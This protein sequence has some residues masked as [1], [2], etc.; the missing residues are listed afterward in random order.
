MRVQFL[1]F[2][3]VLHLVFGQAPK[4]GQNT[5]KPNPHA[6]NLTQPYTPNL[7]FLLQIFN[8]GNGLPLSYRDVLPNGQVYWGTKTYLDAGAFDPNGT[9]LP[10]DDIIAIQERTLSRFGLNLYD[11]AVWEIALALWNRWDVAEIYERNILYTSTT[12]P[13]GRENGNPGGIVNIRAD[14]T[15]FKYGDDKISG[16]ALKQITYPG[17]ATHFT[18][19]ADGKPSK[20]GVKKGPGALFYRMIGP[21][22]QM[23][24]PLDGNY[25]NSWK[26]PWPNN[27]H[28]TPWNSYGLIHFN[29]WKPI[30]GENVWGGILGPLQALEIK[31]G[32]NLTNTTCGDPSAEPQLPCDWTKYDSTP[33]P[34]Q[35]AITLLPG[36][37][38]LQS[39]MGSLYH[40]PWGAKI[41]P[42]DSDEG[43]NV[44]NENNSSAYVSLK[45]L[46]AVLKNYTKGGGDEMLT[47]G[48]QTAEKLAKGLED[49]FSKHLLSKDGELPNGVRLA[50]QGGHINST[51]Y[52]PVPLNDVGGIA[53]DCQ[54][55][56][57]TVIGAENMDKWYGPDMAYKI[58][59][60]AKKY[61][62]FYQNGVLAGVGYTSLRKNSSAAPD[63][64]IWSAEWT[65]GAIN[66]CQVIGQQYKALGKMDYYT[67]L[68]KDAQS[69]WNEVTKPWPD[70]LQFSDG[71]YVYANKR[72][73]IPWGWYANPMGATCSTGWAVIQQQN[74]NPFEWG[75]GDKP[76]LQTPPHLNAIQP[77]P[78]SIP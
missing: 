49:W 41:Y 46:A 69:M 74:Y 9:Q 13:A 75:G 44:S 1:L 12:G 58:W 56:G 50:Y 33:P 24:D 17:N 7:I 53:I 29:D 60:G 3:L 4:S 2:V 65:F 26:Y 52:H 15:D 6:A 16:N 61:A 48:Q 66:M 38:A 14:S 37:E 77:I 42:Y 55:W 57:T 10:L 63:N 73:F 18:Q 35:L 54:T 30:I 11:G 72:F 34:V 43:F 64:H 23:I 22:Y 19:D 45:I 71:S 78:S 28:K 25:A 68:M 36:L 8:T 59:V 21:K 70:G 27:D 40:C 5:W 67:E 31:S 62:G 47:Y 32:N 76:K 51:G 39:E 20:T